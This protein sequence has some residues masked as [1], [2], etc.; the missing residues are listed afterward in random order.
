MKRLV[1][2]LL[3]LA[4]A[5][6]CAGRTTPVPR[7]R[8]VWVWERESYAMVESRAAADRAFAFLR[9]KGVNTLYLYADAWQGRN[10]I[11]D[12]A[13]AYRRFIARA[14]AE[15]FKVQ[16]L[17][18]SAYL[19]TEEYV[20]PG[21]QAEAGAMFQRVL[22]YNAAAA[23]GERFDG[24]NYDIE[25]HLLDAWD[26]RETELLLGFLDMTADFARRKRVSGQALAVGPAMPFWWDNIPIAW[27][28]R[29]RPMSE[30]VA[31]LTDY[32]ALMDYRNE[33]EGNDGILDHASAEMAY[34]ER[35]GR[36]VVI[37]LELTPGEPRKITFNHLGE[38]D[39][40]REVGLA[41]RALRASPAFGGFVFHHYRGYVDWVERQRPAPARTAD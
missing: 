8:A 19:H 17:L 12:D 6:P 15:G 24:V 18:G 20:L 38:A 32:V 36:T 3:V 34:A 35:A 27:R 33:S 7:D 16:A 37:G 30:H 41:E 25:P 9:A 2:L 5:L 28:G 1:P 11:V 22:D 31:D 40:A 4:C 26:T 29:T 23:D 21:R 14:H 10:L 39:L 13:A